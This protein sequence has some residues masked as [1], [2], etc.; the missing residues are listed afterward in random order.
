MNF[1]PQIKQDDDEKNTLHIRNAATEGKMV[2]G[3]TV[4][5]NIRFS[6]ARCYFGYDCFSF[7]YG[8]Q[9]G[10]T[11][12]HPRPRRDPDVL[13]Y[14]LSS[15]ALLVAVLQYSLLDYRSTGIMYYRTGTQGMVPGNTW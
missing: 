12:S 10:F 2:F 8:H 7:L 14:V 4:R 6:A 13:L 15:R 5:N 1:N 11:F 3:K 9:A